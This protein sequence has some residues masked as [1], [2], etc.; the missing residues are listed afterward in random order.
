MARQWT[1][2][3][4]VDFVLN[5]SDVSVW[6]T[7]PAP[8]FG[9]ARGTR[10]LLAQ[11]WL[12]TVRPMRMLHRAG[13]RR[14]RRQLQPFTAGSRARQLRRLNA[15]R[16]SRASD[17]RALRRDRRVLVRILHAGHPGA[18]RGAPRH[19]VADCA[20]RPHAERSRTALTHGGTCAAISRPDAEFAGN[21][22]R[23]DDRT[24]PG[25]A[26][27]AAESTRTTSASRDRFMELGTKSY[28]DD[29]LRRDRILG[30]GCRGS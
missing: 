3:V 29:L 30:I 5:G 25:I 16:M 10:G 24:T 15:S 13:R 19:E 14:G 17:W 28:V 27:T 1:L 7:H 9:A 4:A 6:D 21:V 11:R 22:S 20:H 18:R 23:G 26:V 2:S 8:P 12:L